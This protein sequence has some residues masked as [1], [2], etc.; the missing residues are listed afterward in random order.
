MPT[1]SY[2]REAVVTGVDAYTKLTGG[3]DGT[4]LQDITVPDW[5]HSIKEISCGAGVDGATGSGNILISLR[6]ACV[7]GEQILAMAG[8][9]NIGTTVALAQAT[10]HRKVDIPVTPNKSLEIWAAWAGGDTGSPEC[11]VT[12]TFSSATGNHAYITRNAALT[13]V[14][15]WQTLN[16]ENGTTAVN[17]PQVQGRAI[18]QV[19]AV[20]GLS[21]TTQEPHQVSFRLQG[22]SGSIFGNEHTFTTASNLVSDGTLADASMDGGIVYDVDIPVTKGT[23]RIQ[24]VD[25]SASSTADPELAVTVCFAM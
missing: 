14:D 25:S 23:L 16:T 1:Q 8:H 21:P 18:E 22:V 2:T 3:S 5:A 19:W 12:V 6:G 7:Y 4:T 9:T 20:V 24:G 10:A 11:Q 17:D 15:V 13:T